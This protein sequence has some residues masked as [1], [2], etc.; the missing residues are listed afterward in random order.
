MGRQ[1]MSSM[2]DAIIEDACA[3]IGLPMERGETFAEWF[4][5]VRDAPKL[6]NG[7]DYGLMP[8]PTSD[9]AALDWLADKALDGGWHVVSPMCREQANTCMAVDIAKRLCTRDGC[10]FRRA[11]TVAPQD[12]E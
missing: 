2:S 1:A 4:E 3:S 9:A 7:R 6:G 12:F 8:Q 5:R 11:R 10:V